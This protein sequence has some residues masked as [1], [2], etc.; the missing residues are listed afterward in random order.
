MSLE[1]AS[2]AA[3]LNLSNPAGTDPRSQGDDHIRTLKGVVQTETSPA[4]KQWAYGGHDIT[5]IDGASFQIDTDVTTEF[6]ADRRVR[7]IGANVGTIYGCVTSST[8]SASTHVN[9][10]WDVSSSLSNEAILAYVGP[11]ATALPAAVGMGYVYRSVE[12][13]TR[14]ITKNDVGKNVVATNSGIT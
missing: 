14:T 2:W 10:R 9:L 11:T 8:Y 6:S 3:Q 7:I 1:S 4:N 12:P 5:V 13:T